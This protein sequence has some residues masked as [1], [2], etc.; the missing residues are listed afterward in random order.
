MST[1]QERRRRFAETG[2]SDNRFK[3]GERLTRAFHIS[4]PGDNPLIASSDDPD[5][6]IRVYW[7]GLFA[8]AANSAEQIVIAKFG[9]SGPTLY[10]IPL[11][12]GSAFSH[13][14]PLDGGVTDDFIINLS[15]SQAV[16]VN[17]TWEELAL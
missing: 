3:G 15:A 10:E 8:P 14:E 11:D 7:I 9:T 6:F 12:A 2:P 5:A 1:L 16:K 13:W 4:T 17:L